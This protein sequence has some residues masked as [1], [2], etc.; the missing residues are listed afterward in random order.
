LACV[1][2]AFQS[3]GLIPADFIPWN[4]YPWFIDRP[5]TE[6]ELIEGSLTLVGLLGFLP[7]LEVVML[8]G[9]KR[10]PPGESHW[11]HSR[12]FGDVG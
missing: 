2:P 4:A 3:A 6:S 9:A 12:P 11:M 10:R 5:R 7:D 1:Q 8:Q